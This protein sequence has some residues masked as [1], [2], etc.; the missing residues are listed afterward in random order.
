MKVMRTA[1]AISLVTGGIIAA[2][3]AYPQTAIAADSDTYP[4]PNAPCEFGSQGGSSCT[5]PN[6][7]GDLYDWFNSSDGTFSGNGC[8]SS[9][10]SSIC[11]DNYG[12]EYRNCTSYV[13]QKVSQEFPG[14]NISGWGNA[15]NWKAA[16]TAAGYTL[17]A[18][19]QVG[20]VADWGSEVADGFGHVA[21]VASV[22]NGVA[23]FDEYNVSGTGAFTNNYT[24]ANHPGGKT[25][26]DW[27][28]HM[29]TP[30][31]GSSGGGSYTDGQ[32]L[33][34]P[35]GSVFEVAGGA[36]IGLP[37]WASVGGQQPVTNVSQAT[38]D[39][40]PKVPKDGT[41]VQDY[42]QSTVYEMAGGAAFGVHSWAEV[43]GQQHV[44]QVPAGTSF[45]N[46]PADG[47]YVEPYGS[48]SVFVSA[49]GAA[50]GLPNWNSVGG[51]RPV[52][53]I[54]SSDLGQF[55]PTP[56]D[57]T[58]IEDYGQPTV[59]EM[60]GGAAFGV[61]TWA[62]VGGQHSVA[63][64]PAGAAE[65]LPTT[66]ADGTYVQPYGS[67]TVYLAA[68]GA[69]FGLPNWNTVGGQ[70]PV[71]GIP[72][73]DLGQFLPEPRDGT[74]VQEYGSVAV[75]EM[76]GGAAEP[77]PNWASVGGQQP[78]VMIPAGARAQLPTSPANG[79]FVE[80]YGSPTVEEIAGGAAFPLPN[81]ASVGGQ[82]SVEQV[83]AGTTFASLPADGTFIEEYGSP[84]VNVTAGG[85][86]LGV[87]S[88]SAVGGPEPVT[89]IPSGS[90][91]SN[92]LAYPQN[93]TYV[94]GY[95]SGEEFEAMNGAITRVTTTPLPAA[96]TVDD[97]AIVNQL[98][99]TE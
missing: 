47:T 99:G 21:Y 36:A 43:G 66:P 3:G 78:T 44:E 92:L 41:F 81:W 50:F 72:A 19:P 61:Q 93:G 4:W 48:N 57:G 26:P 7:K 95:G 67:G 76:A 35:S 53:S 64:V 63:M 56:R 69:A 65:Q 80:P 59:Y 49:G 23:T 6:N 58:F 62:D 51:Q 91:A 74:F 33:Q 9:H 29:G 83:P 10:P 31:D 40:M 88:W 68:G 30:A 45:P 98:G 11:F 34:T 18:T 2:E 60:A 38:I 12:Y 52:A 17:D 37:N 73:G 25:A 55:L 5:N 97:W 54:P 75:E 39:A 32:Y 42:G 16:A 13:A 96:T 1:L 90:I 20:D 79:T 70:H 87:T 85:A 27:Y 86:A 71:V 28:I 77:L 22:T 46:Q 84:T 8:G 94:K 15:A 82:K 24:S 89:T 14:K